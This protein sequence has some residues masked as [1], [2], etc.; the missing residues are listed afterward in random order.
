MDTK[1][2]FEMTFPAE[3]ERL[4]KEATDIPGLDGYLVTKSG[5]VLSKNGWNA[6]PGPRVLAQ[7]VRNGYRFVRIGGERK[8]YTV[9]SL[10][11]RAFVGERPAGLQI[12]HLNGDKSDNR[13]DNLEY[14]TAKEN[15][16]DRKNHGTETAAMI[17]RMYAWKVSQTIRNKREALAK[18]NGEG[19]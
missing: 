2:P 9:H 13:L 6:H 1:M 16:K 15:A 17:G 4:L 14:G 18:L 10:V 11:L 12:R 3:L 8:K 5:V 7:Q 19:K